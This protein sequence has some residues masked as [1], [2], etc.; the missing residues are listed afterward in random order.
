MRSFARACQ[1]LLV[2]LTLS[3]SSHAGGYDPL[4]GVATT[5]G[6]VDFLARDTTR[7]RDIPLR[8]YLPAAKAAAPVVLFSHG[9]GGSRENSAYLGEHWAR[10]GYVAVFLQH[11]GS[12]EVVWKNRPVSERLGAMKSAASLE[13]FLLR[14]RDVPAVLDQLTAWNRTPGHSLA[15][16]LELERVGMSGHSFGAVTTQAVSGQAFALGGPFTEK[17]IRAA[18]M[19]SPSVPKQGD[20]KRAFG[21]VEIPWLLFTGTH[22]EAVIGGATVESRLAVYP[23]LPPGNKYELVLHGAEHSAFSDRALP[24]DQEARNSNHH[25]A[26]LATTTAF[27]DA[28]LRQDSAAKIWLEGPG[29]RAVLEAG[30]RWQHK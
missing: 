4:A 3:A 5:P 25:R 13:N 27:W 12:D 1:W 20:P 11:P 17:R 22:D 8:V 29:V 7:S 10:R 28:Y 9:L 16:R 30:D 6:R 21:E 23:A 2:L 18:V 15:G 26:I 14:A 19:M 24:G